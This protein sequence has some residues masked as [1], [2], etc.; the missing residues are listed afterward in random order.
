MRLG[1]ALP[2][3]GDVQ[4]CFSSCPW[5]SLAVLGRWVLGGTA[6]PSAC[7]GLL[8]PTHREEMKNSLMVREQGGLEA[9]RFRSSAHSE[10]QQP[11]PLPAGLP[12][13]VSARRGGIS[14]ALSPGSAMQCAGGRCPRVLR[15]QTSSTRPSRVV[16]GL[17]SHYP[18]YW[19]DRGGL[20]KFQP[21]L[22]QP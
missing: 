3:G 22:I 5:L 2:G 11:S 15:T 17:P 1:S 8:R 12:R 20:V 9:P 13:R 16:N 4:G 18:S 10:P 14:S 21:C 7:L 6:F 19:G